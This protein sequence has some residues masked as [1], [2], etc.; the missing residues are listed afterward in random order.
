MILQA[1]P[2]K[3][4]DKTIGGSERDQASVLLKTADGGYL[5]GGYSESEAVGG[6]LKEA[7]LRGGNDFWLIKFDANHL[8]QWEKTYGGSEGEFLR[9]IVA[10][11]DGYLL[12]GESNSTNDGNK[13][14][15]QFGSDDYWVV[16]NDFAGEK[17]WDR[18]FGGDEADNLLSIV[19]TSDGGFLLAGD[20]NSG[21]NGNKTAA[22]KG[23]VEAFAADYWV[24]KIDA[25]GNREW[26]QT[27]GGVEREELSKIVLLT[28]GNYLL[29][30]SSFSDASPVEDL[31]GKTE[32]S[33]GGNDYWLVKI[34]PDGSKIWDKTIGGEKSD[35]LRDVVAMAD[36]GYVLAG[37]SESDIG[38]D[39]SENS[40]GR[41]DFWVIK[42]NSN[43]EIDW[44]RTL[45]GSG[46]DDCYAVLATTDGG[47]LVGG[48]SESNISGEK[49]VDSKGVY[50][51]WVLKLGSNGN[52]QWEKT[53]V[54]GSKSNDW[55][56]A[57]LEPAAGEYL[58][59]GY[60]TSDPGEEKT[61]AYLGGGDIWLVLLKEPCI[62]PTIS[63]TNNVTTTPI[64]Q[65]T[66]GVTL[67]VTGC[68]GGTLTWTR[69]GGLNSSTTLLSVPTSATGTLVYS[70]TCTVG[71]C[72]G[73]A[74]T[75]V[76]ISPP[77][78]NGSFD[79]F[80]YG[81][82]CATFRG[83]A[84]DRNKPN[85]PVSVDILDGPNVIATV[86]AEVFRQDLL[87]AGKGNGKHAFLF[88]IPK[89]L[90]D[91]LPKTGCPITSPPASAAAVSS[92]KI[93]PRP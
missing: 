82:D 19:P 5:V 93:R 36:G 10:T 41:E 7:P 75:T 45:G 84:W 28:D 81:A 89:N 74:S 78:V 86:M 63:I 48:E 90:K 33:R 53:L 69:P 50:D 25:S 64:F 55:I 14:S 57:L 52:I 8:K 6:S 80:I 38:G 3:L 22:K 87:N 62:S 72:S 56:R 9:T 71:S 15:E 61:G 70:A 51:Y 39:K 26:D 67:A 2:I 92:S 20:S 43:N 76:V 85:T 88:P 13:E 73:T 21:I 1:Q 40:R 27:Y 42:F 59:A 68:E 11:P 44:Q 23:D 29:G 17:Q 83:W 32:N 65:N 24:V 12:G 47:Y 31:T 66:P 60:S 35:E 16:K 54:T 18:S 34:A 46:D 4:F 77:L 91:G 37:Y 79:G 49:T 30:G 58:L